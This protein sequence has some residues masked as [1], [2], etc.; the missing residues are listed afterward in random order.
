M[1]TPEKQIINSSECYWV[2]D[3][4]VDQERIDGYCEDC[5]SCS[6]YNLQSESNFIEGASKTI[7]K[8][9][10]FNSCG[11]SGRGHGLTDLHEWSYENVCKVIGKATC[12]KHFNDDLSPCEKICR[13]CLTGRKIS[14]FK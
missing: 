13:N 9:H 7:K 1:I 2:K 10:L 14:R 11:S 4:L 8:F 6:F 5:A 12:L 3:H